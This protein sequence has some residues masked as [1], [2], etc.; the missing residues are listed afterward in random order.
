MNILEKIFDK[1]QLSFFNRKNSPSIKAG[2]NITAGGDIIIGDT[3]RQSKAA[4]WNKGEGN[5][6]INT[7]MVGPDHGL[8]DEGK[9]TT[10][11]D[12]DIRSSNK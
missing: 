7:T 6:Y 8:I 10:I 1:L 4:V 5:T 11:I 9:G 3:T 12:S 2:G